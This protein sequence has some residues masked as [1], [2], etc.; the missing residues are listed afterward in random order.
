MGHLMAID[1]RLTF[2]RYLPT[3][4]RP[5]S[6]NTFTTTSPSHQFWGVSR[7]RMP[8]RTMSMQP[9]LTWMSLRKTQACVNGMWWWSVPSS[10]SSH[11]APCWRTRSALQGSWPH[12]GTAG[13][14]RA[15]VVGHG[16]RAAAG[17][18]GGQVNQ[19]RQDARR[20]KRRRLLFPAGSQA[21]ANPH[22]I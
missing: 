13:G 18:L 4:L 11:G 15:H 2:D 22:A 16:A 17:G 9:E 10:A 5:F 14:L 7:D 19:R 12:S 6:A 21:H 1:M 20:L 8:A 3:H